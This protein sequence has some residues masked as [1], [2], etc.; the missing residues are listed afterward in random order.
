VPGGLEDGQLRVGQRSRDVLAHGHRCE[1]VCT[2]G[3]SAR[4][5]EVKVT[6]AKRRAISGSVR[7]K[8]SVS[9]CPSSGR[10]GL[11][12]MTGAVAADHPR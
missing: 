8:L 9:S 2:R 6:S 7:Q 11:P 3:R 10:S 1:R 4:L 5:S 12:M